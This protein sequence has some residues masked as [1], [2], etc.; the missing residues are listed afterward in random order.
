M[1]ESFS[2]LFGSPTEHATENHQPFKTD[3]EAKVARDLRY[4]ELK[5]QKMNV[6]RFVSPGQLRQYWSMGVE[7]G[8]TCKVY[9]IDYHY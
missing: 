9:Y 5:K 3:A 4:K 7:C 1:Q 2:T 8:R 6:V